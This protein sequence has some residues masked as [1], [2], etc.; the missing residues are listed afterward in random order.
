MTSL[1]R[2]SSVLCHMDIMQGD[3]ALSS[4]QCIKDK[5]RQSF[6]I[7]AVNLNTQLPHSRSSFTFVGRIITAKRTNFVS[8]I[9]C[10][11]WLCDAEWK[12][13]ASV[14]SQTDWA[15]ETRNNQVIHPIL[16]NTVY[17]NQA[18]TW[19]VLLTVNYMCLWYLSVWLILPKGNGIPMLQ[20]LIS[21]WYC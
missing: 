6:R 9:R 19:P 7:K 14:L 2:E 10:R 13:H 8:S 12:H 21:N 4:G 1:Q 5:F 18:I 15:E 17:M 16:I 3:V 11:T 20:V